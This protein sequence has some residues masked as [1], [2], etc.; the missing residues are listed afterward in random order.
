MCNEHGYMVNEDVNH[1]EVF[2]LTNVRDL[3]IG[4]INIYRITK[5]KSATIRDHFEMVISYFP[6]PLYE[7]I[8]NEMDK[9]AHKGSN[10]I[11]FFVVF[12]VIGGI[13]FGVFYFDK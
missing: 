4:F 2:N 6:K 8:E 5:G 7:R 3:Q 9:E 10:W 1:Q 13:V 12:I 11:L